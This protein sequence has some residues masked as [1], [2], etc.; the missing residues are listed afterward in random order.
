MAS[1]KA[2]TCQILSLANLALHIGKIDKS[3]NASQYNKYY[4]TLKSL[5]NKLQKLIKDF[6]PVAKKI[7][8]KIALANSCYF[9][10]RNIG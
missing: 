2:F 10:G 7:S 3:I 9:I 6:T 1:T 5:P 8:K 4:K